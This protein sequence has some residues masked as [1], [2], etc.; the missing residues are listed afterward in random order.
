MTN[1]FI[2]Q[3]ATFYL[4]GN[5]TVYGRIIEMTKTMVVVKFEDMESVLFKDKISYFTMGEKSSYEPKVVR[6]KHKEEEEQIRYSY[7]GFSIPANLLNENYE[8]D[9][10]L[11]VSFGSNLGNEKVSFKIKGSDDD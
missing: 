10:D 11:S 2:G 1:D 5:W 4:D 9:E 6:A 8:E 7:P 3:F